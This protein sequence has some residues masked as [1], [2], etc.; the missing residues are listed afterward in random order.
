MSNA[1]A[2][3]IEEV[4]YDYKPETGGGLYLR[5][6]E[7]GQKVRLRLIGR[8]VSFK[9]DFTDEAGKTVTKQN[10][11]WA[12]ID[13]SDPKEPAVR[14]FIAGTM[15][16]LGIKDLALDPEWGDPDGYDL[17][18]ERTEEKNRYYTVKPSNKGQGPLSEDDLNLLTIAGV[19]PASPG[20]WVTAMID[21]TG[22]P[23]S[24]GSSGNAP[25]T[26]EDEDPFA[27]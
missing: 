14:C 24:T 18:V 4:G 9:K 2:T 27:E 11:A 5:L 22:Q 13:R 23:G 20:A 12:V 26:H 3:N 21:G 15:V 1:T 16:F 17:I 7:K 10:F 25:P 19:N 6:K 8:P